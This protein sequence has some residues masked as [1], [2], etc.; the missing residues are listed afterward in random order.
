MA[1]HF[2]ARCDRKRSA[3]T[4]SRQPC[5]PISMGTSRGTG[6]TTG[7]SGGPAKPRTRISSRFVAAGCCACSFA[8]LTGV[9]AL[10]KFS[11]QA[12]PEAAPQPTGRGHW[13][14]RVVI[15]HALLAGALAATA[16]VGQR[17]WS[18]ALLSAV[19]AY[20]FTY[21]YALMSLTVFCA[22]LR[23][24]AEHQIHGISDVRGYAALRNFECNPVTRLLMGAYGFGEHQTHHRHPG[25][26]YYQLPAATMRLAEDH[27]SMTPGP[28]YFGTLVRM[29][30]SRESGCSTTAGAAVL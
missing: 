11:G 22:T 25:I 5:S 2:A 18:A 21:V 9:E 30:R 6:S 16:A 3:A 1:S 28:G 27:Q 26:P 7:T 8:V 23:A 4:S 29:V 24:I 13:F 20:L 10:G 19:A 12:R 15:V 14:V 17:D